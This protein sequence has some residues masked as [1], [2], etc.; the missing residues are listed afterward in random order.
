MLKRILGE[1]GVL[2]LMIELSYFL[3]LLLSGFSV[4]FRLGFVGILLIA[5][6]LIIRRFR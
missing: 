6:S 2:V 1:L 3:L 4:E 5:F